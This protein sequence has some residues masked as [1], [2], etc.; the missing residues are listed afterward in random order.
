VNFI[1]HWYLW[2]FSPQLHGKHMPSASKTEKLN[3]IM[4]Q[5]ICRSNKNVSKS[6]IIGVDDVLQTKQDNKKF[7]IFCHLFI[8][9]LSSHSNQQDHLVV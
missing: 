4:S 9:L 5:N 8:H 7:I 6:N 1:Y 2:A 3:N